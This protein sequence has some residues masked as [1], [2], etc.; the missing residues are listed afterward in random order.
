MREE[1]ATSRSNTWL[2]VYVALVEMTEEACTAAAAYHNVASNA[3]IAFFIANI[4]N[5]S[6]RKRSE[7]M[8]GN[9]KV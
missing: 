5:G 8:N 2:A 9:I 7:R 1:K 4:L 6:N 3:F